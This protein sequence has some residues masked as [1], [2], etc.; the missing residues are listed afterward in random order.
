MQANPTVEGISES[1]HSPVAASAFSWTLMS[2]TCVQVD[3]PTVRAERQKSRLV[4]GTHSHATCQEHL[5]FCP[6]PSGAAAVSELPL[7][8]EDRNQPTS[9]IALVL[10][11]ASRNM[12]TRTPTVSPAG[13]QLVSPSSVIAVHVPC[14][15][16]NRQS[17][18]S[19]GCPAAH[20][21]GRH[22]SSS[23]PP[24]FVWAV[25]VPSAWGKLETQR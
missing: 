25:S 7:T 17:A 15:F 13:F 21:F 23:L 18:A 3:E 20:V 22:C 24:E 14:P 10:A 12:R 6:D 16:G 2:G 8:Y 1:P 19:Q 9:T 4:I 5:L 11:H